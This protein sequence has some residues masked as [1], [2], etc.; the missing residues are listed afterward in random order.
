MEDDAARANK[1]E[2][3][4]CDSTW[5]LR[6]CGRGPIPEEQEAINKLRWTYQVSR[7]VPCVPTYWKDAS[8]SDNH[9][10]NYLDKKGHIVV[11]QGKQTLANAVAASAERA[12]RYGIEAT[13]R[14]RRS[15]ALAQ[16]KQYYERFGGRARVSVKSHARKTVKV[17]DSE[18]RRKK[19]GTTYLVR[20]RKKS[21]DSQDEKHG[22]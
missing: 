20:E 21:S 13:G 18:R 6:R 5:L 12:K 4:G 15:E 1:V 22:W 17:S 10:S 11:E 8:I 16:G 2:V 19:D 7:A 9:R 14:V 3:N